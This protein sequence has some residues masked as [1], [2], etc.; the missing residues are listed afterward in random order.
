LTDQTGIGHHLVSIDTYG[1]TGQKPLWVANSGKPYVTF[2]S[3]NNEALVYN[4]NLIP[5]AGPFHLFMYIRPLATTNGR[6]WSESNTSATH[7]IGL[8][9]DPA[10]P[11]NVTFEN[12]YDTSVQWTVGDPDHPTVRAAPKMTAAAKHMVELINDGKCLRIIIDETECSNVIV[13]GAI[14]TTGFCF[15]GIWLG[16]GGNLFTPRSFDLLYASAH[17]KALPYER[18]RDIKTYIH[19]TCD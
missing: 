10:T 4:G 6:I 9:A 18:A 1:G 15:G 5:A 17:L 14:T 8:L 16:V 19:A 13:N 3:S 11:I 7:F 12:I 2:D